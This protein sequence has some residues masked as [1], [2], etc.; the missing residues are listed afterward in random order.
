MIITKQD[1]FGDESK[2]IISNGI[3]EGAIFP[4]RL[5]N[6]KTVT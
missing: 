6:S 1:R 5:A 2:R 4:I 3:A